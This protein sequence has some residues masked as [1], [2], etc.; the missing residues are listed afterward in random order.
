MLR[1]ELLSH[2]KNIMGAKMGQ[3]NI[4]DINI[5]PTEMANVAVQFHLWYLRR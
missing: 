2:S 3:A 1:G 5:V 4:H